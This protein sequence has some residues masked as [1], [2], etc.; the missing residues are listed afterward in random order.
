MYLCSLVY[1]L[2]ARSSAGIRF[3]FNVDLMIRFMT[4]TCDQSVFKSG[5]VA[6]MPAS[7]VWEIQDAITDASVSCVVFRVVR[8]I[9]E[10]LNLKV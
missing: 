7:R 10:F 1:S 3:T 5:T 6:G 2:C 9:K 8:I 4:I